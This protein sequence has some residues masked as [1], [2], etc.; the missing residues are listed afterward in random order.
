MIFAFLRMGDLGLGYAS[1]SGTL[2]NVMVI[3]T[4]IA[5]RAIEPMIVSPS[6]GK[7]P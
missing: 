2:S 1:R 7:P 5:T 4:G 3:K 6:L